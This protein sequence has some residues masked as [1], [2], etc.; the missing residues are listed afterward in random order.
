M[1]KEV[2]NKSIKI[3][4]KIN[5]KQISVLCEKMSMLIKSGCE[6]TKI[7]EILHNNSEK[8]LKYVFR[9]ISKHIQLGNSLS[10]SFK[11]TSIFSE[12]FINMIYAGETSGRLEE[13]M[14][15]LSQYYIKENE[16]KNKLNTALIYP[17]ILTTVSSVCLTFILV[18]VIPKYQIIFNDNQVN[19]PNITKAIIN[20]SNFISNNFVVILL[21]L[22]IILIAFVYLTTNNKHTKLLCQYLKYNLPIIKN[23]SKVIMASKFSSAFYILIKSGIQII[24]A[25]DIS[26]KV[27]GSE[28]VYQKISIS[29]EYIKKGN[30]ITISLSK[31]EILP[32]FLLDMVGVGEE[33]GKLDETLKTVSEFYELELSKMVE[34]MTKL[35]EPIIILIVG[36]I[37]GVMVVAMLMPM[38]D[39]ILV[40]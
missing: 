2:Q 13:I 37:I 30:S 40:I 16:I 8:K 1:Y 34:K 15:N 5:S 18:Y 33:T 11:K 7:L 19:L 25:I 17:M 3:R 6:I 23:I 21:F 28:Y 29:N 9:E 38:F 31:S 27:V 10:N 14:D 22:L 4:P 32:Q 12:F 39:M 36:G 35:I 26:A 20:I 24:D